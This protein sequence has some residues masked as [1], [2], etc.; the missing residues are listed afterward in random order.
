MASSPTFWNRLGGFGGIVFFVSLAV[1]IVL[2]PLSHSVSEPPFDASSTAFLAYGKSEADLPSPLALVGVL[3]LMGFL[4]FAVV[5][6]DRFRVA[7]PRSRVPSRLVLLTAAVFTLLWLGDLAI[8]F[9]EKFRQRDLD[10]ATAS[11]LFGLANGVFVVSWAALGGFLL[12]AGSASLWSRTLPAWQGWAALVIGLGM[13]LSVA[14]PLTP[15]WFF[16][17][18][19]FFAWV[20]VTSVVLLRTESRN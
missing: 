9:A 20:L 15:L 19:L 11:V 3:G 2:M 5:L 17:Y 10:A 7:E 16:P 4:I 13:W 18:F 6:A 14:V 1:L 12:A 8:G